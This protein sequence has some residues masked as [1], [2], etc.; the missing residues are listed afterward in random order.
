MKT[1]GSMPQPTKTNSSMPNSMKTF[2]QC[3][4]Q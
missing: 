3:L 4:G 1:I 2:V